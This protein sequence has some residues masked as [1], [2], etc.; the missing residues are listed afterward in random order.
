[1]LTS[2][3][4]DATSHRWLAAISAYNFDIHYKS[5]QL[6]ADADGLLR[7]PQEDPYE[8]EE[9]VDLDQKITSLMDCASLS[10]EE[11]NVLDGEAVSS[12]CMCHGVKVLAISD[13]SIEY[14][15]E[16]PAIETLLCGESA[17]PDDLEELLQWPG[18]PTLPGMSI[19]DWQQLQREDENL[20]RVKE[21]LTHDLDSDT[22]DKRLGQPEVALLLKERSK[23]VFV[24]DV[25]YHKIFNQRG[26]AFLQLVMP[27]CL[28][29]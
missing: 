5:G 6:N 14:G 3:K 7:R 19:G 23:L 1:M 29:E 24:D 4:L 27:S 17:V 10:P 12:L 13:E 11:F 16:I 8:D 15:C 25:L 2:A 21:I 22:V 9:S 18:Q 20:A 26:E 28:R